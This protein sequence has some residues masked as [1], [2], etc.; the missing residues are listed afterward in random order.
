MRGEP[1][2]FDVPCFEVPGGLGL[3]TE[4]SLRALEF[5]KTRKLLHERTDGEVPGVLFGV[6][7]EGRHGNFHPL[8]Y[9]QIRR[10]SEWSKRFCKVH[11]AF[12]R[13]RA[14]VNWEWKELDCAHSSDALLM[15]IFCHPQV[16]TSVRVQR[17]LG[18]EAE[19]VPEF[20]FKPRTP[21]CNGKY[22]HTEIDMRLG[23]LLV[24][25][26]LTESNFQTAKS[27]L[28]F[29]Y[30]DLERVFLQDELPLRNGMYLHYQL[31]RGVL[32]AYAGG[33]SFC[34]FCDARRRDLIEAWYAVI[35]AVRLFD[36]RC[37][38]KLLTWQEL[39]AE[40]PMELQEFLGMKYGIFAVDCF[41]R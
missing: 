2:N 29:R 35:R 11:T 23:E 33:G 10:T 32:A 20:G 38:L 36:L 3:R 39:A 26:K 13:F 1:S 14:R 6:D 12:K 27:D 30:R 28:V 19:A 16:L 24:E 15:S 17:L 40:L 22:D 18:I 9:E 21:L 5:A 31:I 37:C 34:V 8:A 4:L 7:D 41:S 25:A